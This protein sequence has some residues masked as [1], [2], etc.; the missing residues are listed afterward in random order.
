[1]ELSV[2]YLYLVF[3]HFCS[4]AFLET[5]DSSLSLSS[6]YETLKEPSTGHGSLLGRAGWAQGEGGDP[7]GGVS[8]KN[9]SV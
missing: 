4:E 3:Y 6:L 9:A 2:I 5:S 1:M 7:Y 8:G